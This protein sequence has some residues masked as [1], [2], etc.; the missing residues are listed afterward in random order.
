MPDLVSQDCKNKRGE[1]SVLSE[2]VGIL[3]CVGYFVRYEPVVDM[4][5]HRKEKHSKAE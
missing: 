3:C 5:N 1:C 2:E 4:N